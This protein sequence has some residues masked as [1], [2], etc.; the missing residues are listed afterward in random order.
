MNDALMALF[1]LM[2]GAE[3]KREVVH[4]DLRD[5]RSVALPVIAALGG[6]IVPAGIFIALNAGG[7]AGTLDMSIAEFAGLGRN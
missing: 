4:G 7:D 3:I 2:V 5:L 6:M 1:F